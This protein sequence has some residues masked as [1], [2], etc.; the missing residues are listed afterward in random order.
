M[1][2]RYKIAIDVPPDYFLC[3][4]MWDFFRGAVVYAL[5]H[6]DIEVK[7]YEDALKD[8]PLEEGY[9]FLNDSDCDGFIFACFPD[10]NNP[11]RHLKILDS[12]E[13][14]KM[15]AVCVHGLLNNSTI[16]NVTYNKPHVARIAARH[17]TEHG[18]RR[19]AGVTNEFFQ[20]DLCFEAMCDEFRKLDPELPIF[21]TQRP[22]Q[23]HSILLKDEFPSTR[24]DEWKRF[25][26]WLL[27]LPKPIALFTLA[28]EFARWVQL[29]CD[30]LNI[31]IPNEVGLISVDFS[32][33]LDQMQYRSVTTVMLAPRKNG[34]RA[35]EV[36]HALLR[37][38][39]QPITTIFQ[40]GELLERDTTNTIIAESPYVVKAL[41]YI[42]EHYH[43]LIGVPEVV[44]AAKCS[45]SHLCRVFQDELGRSI[46]AEIRRLR[47]LRVRELLQNT[48]VPLREIAS[49]SGFRDTSHFS[50]VF[51]QEMG[52][53][54]GEWRKK[55]RNGTLP[56]EI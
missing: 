1:M 21:V 9:S 46:M 32:P 45:R 8:R 37:G 39:P 29:A 55:V 13:K 40:S 47:I 14:L 50:N 41:H 42:H 2:K 4:Y 24:H 15:P 10:A 6:K 52:I 18:F 27:C 3:G 17:L 5:E 34:Y 44:Q 12:V 51:Q 43:E 54:P 19:F 48:T 38:E 26:Q 35:M 22:Y 23:E 36:L 20:R 7:L 31:D 25:K 30:E 53:R 11:D 33:I 16:Y 49:I 56:I 28:G